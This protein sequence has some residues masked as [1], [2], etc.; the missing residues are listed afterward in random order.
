MEP[1]E[2]FFGLKHVAAAAHSAQLRFVEMK[3]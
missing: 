2:F 1:P 3:P